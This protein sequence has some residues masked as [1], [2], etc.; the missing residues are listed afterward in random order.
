LGGLS[1]VVVLVMLGLAALAREENLVASPSY[2][3]ALVGGFVA[4]ALLCLAILVVGSAVPASPSGLLANRIFTL[5]RPSLGLSA[6]GVGSGWLLSGTKAAVPVALV[7][8][9]FLILLLLACFAFT[10]GGAQRAPP[11]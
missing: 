9:G 8:F 4:V 5:A 6:L 2:R 11:S 7:V 3:R 10:G 1:F